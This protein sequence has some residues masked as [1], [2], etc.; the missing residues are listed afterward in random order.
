MIVKI[1]SI[2]VVLCNL[3]F[4][5]FLLYSVITDRGAMRKEPGNPI[6]LA[7]YSMG[8]QFLAA[9]GVSD[10]SISIIVFKKFKL[11]DDRNL[12]GTLMTSCVVPV[13]V[14]A[15][16]Y[17]SVT[18][19]DPIT[20]AVCAVSGLLGALAGTAVVSKLDL[21]SIR[22]L[23]IIALVMAGATMLINL[24]GITPAGGSATGFS[25]WKLVIAAAVTFV[26]SGL[27]MGGFA[28]TALLLCFFYILGLD[29]LAAFP[30][31]MG[32]VS[33]ACA[34]GGAKYVKKGRYNKKLALFSTVFGSVGAFIAVH[35]VKS[36][37]T[38]LLQWIILGV[39][40]YSAVVMISDY[41]RQRPKKHKS[42]AQR[43]CAKNI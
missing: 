23:M 10:F 33:L 42:K 2:I 16:G 30:L 19:V 3:A 27:S 40:V 9:F 39:I 5:A 35:F 32:T 43:E 38:T 29:Q 26:L 37:D 34:F 4:A 8:V 20:L 7:L 28:V 22:L 31:A 13:A 17:L 18:R 11:V 14:M 21:S 15:V 12:P 24:L 1:Y 25:G 36:L 6:A 41:R